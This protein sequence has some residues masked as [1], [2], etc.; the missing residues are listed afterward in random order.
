M[1]IIPDRDFSACPVPFC[2]LLSCHTNP[3]PGP[4]LDEHCRVS[5]PQRKRKQSKAPQ[6]RQP[7]SA[8]YAGWLTF[9]TLNLPSP[10][11]RAMENT[12]L[13]TPEDA[14]SYIA[15]IGE[16]CT[17][18]V[19]CRCLSP[20]HSDSWC[21]YAI[22]LAILVALQNRWQ[23]LHTSHCCPVAPHLI[24]SHLTLSHPIPSHPSPPV[25]QATTNIALSPCHLSLLLDSCYLG[26]ASESH[27]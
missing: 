27:G 15:P 2:P 12:D 5:S 13:Q 6:T 21:I 24:S 9:Q 26:L 23:G 11:H 19:Q 22:S 10:V 16:F 4:R 7:K 14:L 3:P 25:H 8:K 20:N 17:L 1:S 18:Y